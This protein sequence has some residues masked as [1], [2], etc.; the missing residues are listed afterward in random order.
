[1]DLRDRYNLVTSNELAFGWIIN[2][3]FFEMND[4][5]KIDFAHN[6]FSMVK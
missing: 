3:P 5:G 4:E 1:L 6:P 2:F